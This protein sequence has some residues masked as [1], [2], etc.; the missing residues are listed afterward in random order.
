[1]GG[2]RKKALQLETKIKDVCPPQNKKRRKCKFVA[3]NMR[4]KPTRERPVLS[5]LQQ[6]LGLLRERLKR[7]KLKEKEANISQIAI[8]SP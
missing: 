1:M 6:S 3:K 5:H 8:I 2:R 7:G 4:K